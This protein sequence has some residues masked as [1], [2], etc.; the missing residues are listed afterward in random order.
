LTAAVFKEFIDFDQGRL[1]PDTDLHEES[2]L[3]T[4]LQTLTVSVPMLDR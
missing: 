1:Q 2:Q 4:P 3:V